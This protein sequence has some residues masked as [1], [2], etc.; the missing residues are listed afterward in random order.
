MRKAGAYS[1]MISGGRHSLPLARIKKIMKQSNDEG[2]AMMISGEAPIVF[3]RAC[4]LLIEE[5]SKKSWIIAAESKKKILQ[6]ED[7]VSAI[8]A[9]DVFDF[10]FNLVSDSNN[11]TLESY[12]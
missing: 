10:L 4:E 5:L 1:R 3:S 7:V 12:S 11:A 8:M 9:T 2:D 6:K